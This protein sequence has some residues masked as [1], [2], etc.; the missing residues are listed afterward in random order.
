M[1]DAI[2]YHSGEDVRVGD[3]VDVGHGNGPKMRVVVI[4]PTGEAASGFNASEWA[5]L[6]SGVVLQDT[7]MFGLLHLSEL[8]QEQVLIGRA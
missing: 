6:S 7:K 8:D 1:G 5:Y 2:K 4:I 3:V